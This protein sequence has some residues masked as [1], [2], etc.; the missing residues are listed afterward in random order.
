MTS[1]LSLAG[2]RVGFVVLG[3]RTN[4]YEG[5]AL[6]SELAERGAILV[7]PSSEDL[8]GVVLLTCTVTAVADRKVRQE[9]RRLRRRHPRAILVAAGCWAQEADPREARRLG[10]DH[11]VGNRLKAAIP[12]LL[13]RLRAGEEVP[14]LNRRDVGS[15]EDWDDLRLS[16]T[17]RHTRAF[18]KVQDGCDHFCSYCII[19]YVRGR[20]VSRPTD[21]VLDEIRSIVAAGCRE[22]VLSGI[23]LGD[24]RPENG[25]SLAALVARVAETP[26]VGR[27]R[28]GS[29]EPFSVDGTLLRVLSETPA[30]CRHL[31]LPLQS[32][33]DGI[34]ARMRRGHTAGDFID[35]VARI[36]R[37]LGE[38]VHIS[39]DVL[40]GFP[41]ET[42][43]AFENTLR[44]LERAGIGRTHAFPFSPRKGT[45]AASYP[46]RVPDEILSERVRRVRDASDA[47]LAAYGR[48]FAGGTVR[49]LVERSSD[50]GVEGLIPEYLRVEATGSAEQGTIANVLVAEA[51]GE[52]LKGRVI[53]S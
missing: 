10:A 2:Y 9:L 37:S 44:V 21:D 50:T 7:D 34:L 15:C 35:L 32:G 8:D 12:D 20:S 39:T 42:P 49:I 26:G 46:D 30:F 41:G 47:R 13:S 24:Y 51:Q 17:C 33:D 22:V 45:P 28:F 38:D 1:S 27:I 53:A 4:Q 6:A 25:E 52:L 48:R 29:L 40:V 31:H 5:D 11:L 23:H 36:R 14:F 16:R 19:P 43:E 3:C 18:V